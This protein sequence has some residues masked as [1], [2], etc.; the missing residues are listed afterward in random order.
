MKRFY[1]LMFVTLFLVSSLIGQNILVNPGFENF[2]PAFW[3]PL[4][5]AIGSELGWGDAEQFS[6][7]YS[8]SVSKSAAT[9]DVVGWQYEESG[10]LFWNTA[11][12][13]TFNLKAYVKTVGVN[14]NPVN[15]DARIG[16]SFEYLNSS[17]A[18]ITSYTVWAD[19]SVASSAGWDTLS[20]PLIV[21]A[22]PAVVRVTAF[23]GKAATGTVYF[24]NVSGVFNGGFETIDGWL[25]WYSSSNGSY[26]T[27]TDNAAKT[28]SYAA[29]LFKPDTTSSTSEIVYYSIPVAVEAG[30]WYKVGVWVKTEG[31]ND[32]A[33]FEPT[34]ITK[35]RLDDRLGLCYF[36][37]T[38]SITEK[39]VKSCGERKN[40]SP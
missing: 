31:V 13:G 10:N 16:V 14:M 12:A 29:E 39:H 24:D 8:V 11:A 9:T 2:K 15:D 7:L 37:H 18:E 22:A 40:S 25:N 19:Q 23:M 21:S 28:G 6:G 17:G 32:S 35:E 26:G 1:M 4:N 20:Y 27:V 3:S 36:F 38:G 5:G 33:A 34:Y 30:A